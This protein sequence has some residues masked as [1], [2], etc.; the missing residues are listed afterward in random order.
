MTA[1]LFKDEYST[2]FHSIIL[3]CDKILI[4][5]QQENATSVRDTDSIPSSSKVS[6]YS[7]PIR[8]KREYFLEDLYLPFH[9]L[10]KFFHELVQA[11]PHLI[12]SVRLLCRK[13]LEMSVANVDAELPILILL[14]KMSTYDVDEYKGTQ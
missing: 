14:E 7:D 3:D 1:Y 2:L 12:Q 6:P 11:A 4:S 8:S 10:G 9:I 5:L 13:S